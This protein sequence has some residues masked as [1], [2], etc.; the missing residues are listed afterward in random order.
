MLRTANAAVN[1]AVAAALKEKPEVPSNLINLAGRQRMLLQ[2]M[3]KEAVLYS[4]FLSM[5]VT[6]AASRNKKLVDETIGTFVQTHSDLLHGNQILPKT[7]NACILQQ[8]HA[9]WET[10]GPFRDDILSVVNG[11]DSE[12][13]MLEQKSALRR[14]DTE[15]EVNFRAMHK[16]VGWYAKGVDA[17]PEFKV[18]LYEWTYKI[19]TIGHVYMLQQ[20]V[21]EQSFLSL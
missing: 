7:T 15:T 9:V 17:C 1:D 16:A 21:V 20:K 4:L 10:F 6:E 11:N 12:E 19:K 13:S 8:M 18:S 5:G 3:A 14:I 2:K